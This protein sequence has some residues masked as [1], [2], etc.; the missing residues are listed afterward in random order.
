MPLLVQTVETNF[1]RSNGAL[2]YND[3]F[4]VATTVQLPLECKYIE[5]IGLFPT[6]NDENVITTSK[7]VSISLND[8]VH[9]ID[10]I[11]ID[12]VNSKHICFNNI[13]KKVNISTPQNSFIRI[14][15]LALNH[16]V[17]FNSSIKLL[18]K[19]R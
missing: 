13:M 8:T 14:A 4:A 3:G 19:W 7:Y 6:I 12:K 9:I 5:E 17:K 15:P 11:V 2:D 18:I 1:Y 10:E 16:S